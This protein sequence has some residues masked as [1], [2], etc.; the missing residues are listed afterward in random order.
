MTSFPVWI[1]SGARRSIV[2]RAGQREI[3]RQVHRSVWEHAPEVM[4]IRHD[5]LGEHH[6]QHWVSGSDALLLHGA[7][8]ARLQSLRSFLFG[9]ELH[10]EPLLRAR[11]LRPPRARASFEFVDES[12]GPGQAPAF[13]SDSD[14]PESLQRIATLAAK[15]LTRLGANSPDLS[16]W[17]TDGVDG[18]GVGDATRQDATDATSTSLLQTGLGRSGPGGHS[19][20]AVATHFGLEGWTLSLKCSVLIRLAWLRGGRCK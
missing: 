14:P 10:Q 12:S 15:W 9:S 2:A 8:T 5:F 13:N 17:A 18:D 16:R 1:L 7:P 20:H 6:G 11:V 4:T 3:S 19:V